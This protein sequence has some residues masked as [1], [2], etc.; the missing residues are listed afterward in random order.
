MTQTLKQQAE[1]LGWK[2]R[3]ETEP[4]T[5]LRYDGLGNTYEVLIIAEDFVV[6]RNL[7][8]GRPGCIHEIGK[9]QIVK[10][11]PY[12]DLAERILGCQTVD[13]AAEMLRGW[14]GKEWTVEEAWGLWCE[15]SVL[16]N[17]TKI[18]LTTF[19]NAARK[20]ELERA[21]EQ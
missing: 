21:V 10:P 6:S 13:G 3:M 5:I 2:A 11:D 12:R 4:G 19:L 20:H 17:T 7:Q 8:S 16:S 14:F 1:K 15:P 18:G 9:W